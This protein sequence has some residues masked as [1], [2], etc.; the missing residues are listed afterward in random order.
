[1]RRFTFALA[2]SLVLFLSSLT[3]AGEFYFQIPISKLQ[4]TQG[5]FPP[6]TTNPTDQESNLIQTPDLATVSPYAV[7]DLPGEAFVAYP[8]AKFPDFQPAQQNVSDEVIFI[9]TDQSAD[10]TGRI[11]FTKPDGTGMSAVTFRIPSTSAQLQAKEPFLKTKLAY[12][13]SLVQADLP[14]AAW[15]RHQARLAAAALGKTEPD[16][17]PNFPTQEQ[18]D[19]DDSY[20]LFTGGRAVSESLQL[21]RPLPAGA[22][23]PQATTV[24][25]KSIDGIT[26]TPMD[27]Q[28]QIKN[29]SPQ[30]DILAN[31]IPADQH[32]LFLPN[33]DALS[34]LMNEAQG[35]RLPIVL[36]AAAQ[37]QDAMTF[38][39]YQRQ[40]CVSLNALTRAAAS[41][42]I[43]SIAITGSDPYLPVGSDLTIIFQSND[44]AALHSLLQAQITSAQQTNPDAKPTDGQLGPIPYTGAAA[45][46]HSVSTYLARFGNAVV[47]TNSLPQ[48]Q[49]IAAVSQG[50]EPSLAKQPE[51]TFF[52]DR[53]RLGDPDETALLILSDATIRRWCS[54][55]WRIANSRRIR[56]AAVMS[57]MQATYFDKLVHG[58]VKPGPIYSDLHLTD[59]G[60]LSLTPTGVTSS[61]YGSLNMMTPISELPMDTV[62]QS[63][64]DAYK[65]WRDSYEQNWRWFFD[66]IAVK[67]SITPKSLAADVTVMPLIWGSD[68][69]D[70]IAIAQGV[71]FPPDAG[72]PHDALLHL[73]V[74]INRK[75]VLEQ[76]GE[77]FVTNIVPGL[78]ADP[79]SWLGKSISL[80]ADDDPFWDDLA[81]S[82]NTYDFFQNNL[83]RLPIALR[84]DVNNGLELAGFLVALHAFVEQSAP[85][86]TLWQNLTCKDHAYVKIS[87]SESAKTQTPQVTN[88]AI[89]YA[90]TA[91]SLLITPSEALLKRALDREIDRSST[92]QAAAAPTTE[93]WLGSSA[94]LR[95]QAKIFDILM[96]AADSATLYPKQQQFMQSLAWKNLPILNEWKRRYPDQDPVKL[97]EHFW[98][99]RLLDP[100]GGQYVWNEKWQ[101]MESTSYGQPGQPKD[102]PTDIYGWTGLEQGEFGL[103]FEDQGVRA[104]A[105]LQTKNQN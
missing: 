24:D 82:N 16:S 30:L 42:L 88:V 14:G 91:Q 52:R 76:T 40:L 68:Y 69:R 51:Y 32:A 23:K 63:E 29:L 20:D 11:F 62:T 74:A 98:G 43:T 104:R 94:A 90:A 75:A 61:L 25:T 65:R 72:D 33:L 103:T 19:L 59:L 3:F 92:T 6:P 50:T 46:D 5:Q 54:P 22:A 2:T 45:P 93:P 47:L 53:Y 60:D 34:S 84:A 83:G 44:P 36:R 39:R 81:K 38:D 78:K 73:I 64:A 10:V 37:P 66:P 102:G 27:W 4:L 100:A 55:R 105:K 35:S 49:R 67:F 97:Q 26:V 15:F 8:T 13:Q 56:A 58:N 71:S 87:P 9:H 101:T 86:M 1:M 99:A 77:N 80:Y 95:A 79:F 70:M 17:N 31:L 96:I 28:S 57:E 21:D 48:L 18:D 41:P 85:Q 7:L 12:Y 89:Y